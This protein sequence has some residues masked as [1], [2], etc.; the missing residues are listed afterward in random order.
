M[1][2]LWQHESKSRQKHSS[3]KIEARDESYPTYYNKIGKLDD[4]ETF[5]NII[6][7]VNGA[8]GILVSIK[9]FI[10]LTRRRGCRGTESQSEE[11]PEILHARIRAHYINSREKMELCMD[12][13]RD[14]LLTTKVVV[15]EKTTTG[16][17]SSSTFT[18]ECTLDSSSS[19]SSTDFAIDSNMQCTDIEAQTNH[20]QNTKDLP[21]ISL[22]CSMKMDHPKLD[23]CVIC[24]EPYQ[25]N[26]IVSYSKHQSCNHVFHTG[27]IWN[28][29]RDECRNDCPVCRCCITEMS[30]GI[31]EKVSKRST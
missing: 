30:H 9:G 28:W 27:C 24:L 8:M 25:E 5:S 26:D 22:E 2:F 12:L 18:E 16:H 21:V 19:S 13:V 7:Q 31:F 3:S 14:S 23:Q 10:Y 29:L 17:R 1:T 15:P 6:T 4:F 11:S 20:D